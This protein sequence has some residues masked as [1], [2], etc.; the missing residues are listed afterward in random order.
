MAFEKN[1]IL[2]VYSL[3][4]RQSYYDGFIM[5]IGLINCIFLLPFS[6]S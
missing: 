2:S 6:Y 3:Q 4:T 1:F 5:F